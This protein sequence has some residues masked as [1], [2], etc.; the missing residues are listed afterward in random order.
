MNWLTST[1]RQLRPEAARSRIEE[2][3]SA[4][5]CILGAFAFAQVDKKSAQ[6][7]KLGCFES[8]TVAADRTPA[9]MAAAL[10]L[11]LRM[12]FH[13]YQRSAG[14]HMADRNF[15]AGMPF[16]HYRLLLHTK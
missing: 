16:L 7:H 12:R 13:N 14:C 11:L 2:Q 1:Q 3:P 4:A 9:H 6:L 15:A 8:T 5:G 10:G